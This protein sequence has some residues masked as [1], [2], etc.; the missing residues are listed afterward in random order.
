MTDVYV[1]FVDATTRHGVKPTAKAKSNTEIKTPAKI[2]PYSYIG[3]GDDLDSLGI[4]PS[5]QYF[6][7]VGFFLGLAAES[8]EATGLCLLG[9]LLGGTAR[10]CIRTATV[11]DDL[12]QDPSIGLEPLKYR[13]EIRKHLIFC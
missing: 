4:L 9:Y 10:A 11:N 6:S 1:G 8:P 13:T 5:I 12:E 7:S 3:D 2:D